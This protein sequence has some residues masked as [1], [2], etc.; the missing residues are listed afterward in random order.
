MVM[1]DFADRT[2]LVTGS[3]TGIGKA[4][5][6]KFASNGASIII[7]GRRKEPLEEAAAELRDIA[8]EAGSGGTIRI[9]DGVDVSD[10]ASV[11]SMIGALKD[12]G[13]TLDVLVNNAGV[14]GPVICFPSSPL[15][16]FKSAVA[17][18]LTGT[19]WVSRRAL[20][21]MKEGSKIITISTFFS[22]ERPL[23]QRPYRF[24]SPYTASQG[25]KNR[26]AE[27]ISWELAQKGI[28]SIATNPGPV[29]SDRIYKTV[30]PKA[31]AE[32][33]RVSGF[34]ELAPSEVAAAAL[35][36]LPLLGEDDKTVSDGIEKAAS[37]L[38][39]K[40]SADVLTR[41]LQKI[42]KIAEKIQANTSH[43]IADK[44]FLAQDDVAETVLRLS[45]DRLAGILNG[46]VVP[47]D[48]VFYPVKPHIG[49][50]TP[51]VPPHDFG[52]DCVVFTV[53]IDTERDLARLEGMIARIE[54]SNGKPVCFVS[55]GTPK[56]IQEKITSKH[57]SH[58]IDISD[59][60]ELSRWFATAGS[61]VGRV[62][63]VVHMTGSVPHQKELTGLDRPGWDRLVERFITIP[64]IVSQG[65]LECLVPGGGGDPRLY[66]GAKGAIMIVGP[67]LPSEKITGVQRARI[68]VF[69]GALRPFTTTVNQELGDVLKSGV[70]LFTILPGTVAGTPSDDGR[71]SDALDF[72]LSDGAA[73]S[74]EVTFC[75]DES[76]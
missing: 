67:E 76:R 6:K 4:I 64:A 52:G 3:G 9:F 70:R 1:P 34:E 18:H 47:G 51:A 30:Y 2:V 22:E 27:A 55:E 26:L 75:V 8:S 41:L 65:A 72:A 60:G 49:G 50:A 62:C 38:G 68:E 23:E 29:H 54:G 37:K 5:A 14:S 61:K 31:A 28:V 53:D 10:H 73:A 12:D 35:E 63:C 11:D 43:M 36:I 19:F 16:E 46:K 56:D 17:I 42:Q 45:D 33:L 66:K 48:R 7:M 39:G 44:E 57:H 71:L 32:F 74:S 24:R 69:R 25:A 15:A 21:I 58:V 40:S 13:V 59:P 20:D